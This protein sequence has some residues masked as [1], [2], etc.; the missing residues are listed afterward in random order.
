MFICSIAFSYSIYVD[1]DADPT[2]ANGT[3]EHPFKTI[4]AAIDHALD[5]DIPENQE[6]SCVRIKLSDYTPGYIENLQINFT[7]NNEVHFIND[8]TIESLSDNPDDCFILAQ[9]ISNPIILCAGNSS[10]RLS[11]KGIGIKQYLSHPTAIHGH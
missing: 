5:D 1:G 3:E 4:Q 8:I 10:S 9:D 11:V 7:D 6:S 2:I